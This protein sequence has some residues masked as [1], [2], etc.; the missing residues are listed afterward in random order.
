QRVTILC[1]Q[2]PLTTQY[3]FGPYATPTPGRQ[4]M[5]SLQQ[6]QK[7]QSEQLIHQAQAVL[8]LP[9]LTLQTFAQISEP[10]PLICQVA[11]QQGVNLIL[12]S[13]DRRAP[14]GNIRLGATGDYVIHH[15][16]CPVLL[17]R[18]VRPE[19]SVTSTAE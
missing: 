14:L 6:A 3:L 2:P 5:Q 12:L 10:G 1:V 16:P 18:A 19:S 11:Q 13:S 4:L 15:A 17:C 9:G 8:N 7:E